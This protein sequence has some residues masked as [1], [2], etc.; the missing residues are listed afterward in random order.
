MLASVAKHSN[1]ILTLLKCCEKIN[2][3][4]WAFG[5]FIGNVISDANPQQQQ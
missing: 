1:Y 3:Y 5:K 2:I 4:F